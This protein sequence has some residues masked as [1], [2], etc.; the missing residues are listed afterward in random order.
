MT[1]GLTRFLLAA[2]RCWCRLL[3]EEAQLPESISRLHLGLG[4]LVMLS[5]SSLL[6]TLSTASSLL[7]GNSIVL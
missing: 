5:V 7:A 2:V 3:H 4:E 6:T 1:S